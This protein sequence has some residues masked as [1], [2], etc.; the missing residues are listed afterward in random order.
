[1]KQKISLLVLIFFVLIHNVYS[2]DY[3]TVVFRPTSEY[4]FTYENTV[5]ET[6]IY[7]QAPKNVRT[8]VQ[9]LPDSVFLISST[10]EEIIEEGQKGTL[11]QITLRFEKSGVY[12]LSPIAARIGWGSALL[13]FEPIEVYTNPATIEPVANLKIVALEDI[14]QTQFHVGQKIQAILSL[15]YFSDAISVIRDVSKDFLCSETQWYKTLPLKVTGFSADEYLLVLYEFTPL[16]EGVLKLPEIQIHLRTCGLIDK[17]IKAE[18]LEINVINSTLVKEADYIDTIPDYIYTE[19][20]NTEPGMNEKKIVTDAEIQE[21]LQ[22]ETQKKSRLSLVFKLFFALGAFFLVL[23]V[24]II[25][26]AKKAK[27]NLLFFVILSFVIAFVFYF[28]YI[29]TYGIILDQKINSIPDDK[30][31]QSFSVP[32][33]S[34]VKVLKTI[35]GWNF[36][37]SKEKVKGWIQQSKIVII[38]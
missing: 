32:A 23:W 29:P 2:A 26:I 17:T 6:I 5:F 30:S 19:S 13:K 25:L 24:V 18:P 34:K 35:D 15:K 33:G 28:L 14:S 9:S 16:K 21:L 27:N 10:T 12:K 38:K 3:S 1:M 20:R 31:I 36:I 7:N 11:V 8:T 4:I 22:V 37:S